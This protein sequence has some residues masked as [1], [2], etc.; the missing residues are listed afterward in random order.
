MAEKKP[1]STKE[2]ILAG[3]AGHTYEPFHNQLL[4]AIYMRPEKTR[5]GIIL[6]DKTLAEDQWQGKV[7][8]VISKAKGAFA[9]DDHV[10]FL[11]DIAVGEWA[12]YRVS[13][14]F[15]IDIQGIHCRVIE[16]VHIRGRVTDPAEI[17]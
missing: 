12:V 5:G 16:D 6:T 4:I 7:G 17:Y 11:D 3:L 1:Q 2:E 8:L 9:S 14:G 10:T 15:S 13:D